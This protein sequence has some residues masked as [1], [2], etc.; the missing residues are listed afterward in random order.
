MSQRP[1]YF[2]GHAN[3]TGSVFALLVVLSSGCGTD[4]A[5]EDYL[6]RVGSD[7]LYASDLALGDPASGDS[8]GVVDA[9][10]QYVEHWITT[11]LLHREAERLEIDKNVSVSRLL[12]DNRRSILAS[13]LM[14]RLYDESVSVPDEAKLQSYFNEFSDRLRIREPYVRVRYLSSPDRSKAVRA[15]Q[16]LQRALRGAGVDS[17]WKQIVIDYADDRD[18]SNYLSSNYF[19]QNRL[20]GPYPEVQDR[21]STLGD[22]QV[23]QVIES[24][25]GFHVLQLVKRAE[26][27]T[28]PELAWVRTE[29][30]RQLELQDQKETHARLVQRLRTEAEARNEIEIR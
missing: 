29:I 18:G 21:L 8:S 15:R 2:S 26:N 24:E 14:T 11:A 10:L 5:R 7:Y 30:S 27:G 25:G 20:F 23:S 9:R 4:Q 13:A 17:L 16:L 22:G 3:V 12:S 6:A 19:P 28:T 1:S